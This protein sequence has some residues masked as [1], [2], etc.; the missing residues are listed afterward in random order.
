MARH[1]SYL[2]SNKKEE[3]HGRINTS[4]IEL[5]LKGAPITH[6]PFTLER[7][8]SVISGNN[9]SFQYLVVET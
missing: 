6:G 4:N 5:K 7:E 2:K 3:S 9:C 8:Q 1:Q